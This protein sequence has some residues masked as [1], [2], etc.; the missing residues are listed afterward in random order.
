MSPV[1]WTYD[2][3]QDQQKEDLYHAY[4]RAQTA[5]KTPSADTNIDRYPITHPELGE[6]GYVEMHT[7]KVTLK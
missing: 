1:Q 5:I 2:R 3:K 7:S 4:V 6:C